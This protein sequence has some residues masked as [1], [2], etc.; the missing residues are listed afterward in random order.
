MIHVIV[1]CGMCLQS[2]VDNGHIVKKGND[3]YIHKEVNW[4]WG[5]AIYP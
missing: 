5:Y 4:L 3:S 2:S 1:L